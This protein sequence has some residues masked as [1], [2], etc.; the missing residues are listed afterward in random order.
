MSPKCRFKMVTLYLRSVLTP[1]CK[2]VSKCPSK[3]TQY[4]RKI[5]QSFVSKSHDR[6]V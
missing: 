6:L 2:F 5:V 4:Q 3:I 1:S